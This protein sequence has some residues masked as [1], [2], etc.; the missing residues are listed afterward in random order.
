[1]GKTIKTVRDHK[2]GRFKGKRKGRGEGFHRDYDTLIS[3]DGK[4]IPLLRVHRLSYTC[5]ILREPMEKIPWE[6][7]KGPKGM[8]Q[9]VLHHKFPN[10]KSEMDELKELEITFVRQKTKS[11]DE[12]VIYLPEKY[13]TEFELEKTKKIMEEYAW[14][15]RKW[16]QNKY[17]LWLGLALPYCDMEIAHEIFDPA[18][19]RWVQ[20][21]GMA[22]VKTKRGYGIVDESKKGFPER[23][24]TSIEQVKADLESGDRI[25]DLE[26]QMRFMM[27]QQSQLMEQQGKMMETVTELTQD[28][29]EFMGFRRKLEERLEKDSANMFS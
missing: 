2:T 25:L 12:L 29:H 24:F 27:Q 20:E 16:F 5:T 4:R 28:I 17:K 3:I 21:N 1:M 19:R 15:A 8:E 6:K 26:E 23:E 11:Y 22:K 7:K 10:K 14:N 9:W 18:L 13:I